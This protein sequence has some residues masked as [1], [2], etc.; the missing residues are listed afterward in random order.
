MHPET[1][2]VVDLEALDEA[3]Q[4]VVSEL[5]GQDLNEALPEV[6]EEGALPST[7]N[8]ARWIWKRLASR[9]SQPAT[10]EKVRVAESETLAAEYRG[11]GDGSGRG[12]P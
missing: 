10:L 12:A 2:F 1:G 8:L 5:D 6:R 4:E 9:V 11:S 7:E 3:I